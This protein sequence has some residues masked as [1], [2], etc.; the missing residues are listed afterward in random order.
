MTGSRKFQRV[1]F[2]TTAPHAQNMKNVATARAALK[3]KITALPTT[4]RLTRLHTATPSIIAMLATPTPTTFMTVWTVFTTK[5]TGP[6][7]TPGTQSALT[8]AMKQTVRMVSMLFNQAAMGADIMG[9]NLTLIRTRLKL[10]TLITFLVAQAE[11]TKSMKSH[12]G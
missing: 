8:P 2:T 12:E 4:P 1:T 3:A 9:S 5:T 11:M 6:S 7:P 10:P